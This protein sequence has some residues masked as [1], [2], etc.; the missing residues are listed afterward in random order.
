MTLRGRIVIGTATVLLGLFSLVVLAV[1]GITRTD[2]GRQRVRALVVSALKQRVHG[3]VYVGRITE[4]FFS[5]VTIDSI[6]IRDPDDSLFVATGR[7]SARY[8][9]RDLLDRRILLR[10]V[11]AEHPVV[12]IRQYENGEWNFRR[13]FAS[14]GKSRFEPAQPRAFIVLDSATI[15]NAAFVLTLP[16][17]PAPWLKGAALDSA[18]RFELARKDHEILRT[19]E[20]FSRT[21]RWTDADVNIPLARI[22]DPDSAGMRFDFAGLK[23]TE[24]DPPFLFSNTRG[25][26][27]Q[28][29][30]S[31][32]L[33][34]PHLDLPASTGRARGKIV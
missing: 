26:V 30:D 23:V 21:W 34:I 18:I 22:S 14:G 5:G 3:S 15:R 33:D 29:G 6:E 1:L 17:H 27:R 8:D 10:D 20:G 7:V 4:G 28:L 24:A 19:R 31:V 16:W 32:W 9:L 25:T 2:R 11:H 12:H 13:V